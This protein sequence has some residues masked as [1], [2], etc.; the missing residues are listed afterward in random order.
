MDKYKIYSKLVQ[1]ITENLLFSFSQIST[2]NN[3]KKNA[4]LLFLTIISLFSYAQQLPGPRLIVRGDDMGSSRSA[5]LASIETFVNGIETSIE[6]MVVT[7]W[8]PEAVQMLK[9]NTGIDVGLHLVITSE[10]DGI[11]WRP[12]N[13]PSLTDKDGYFY[14]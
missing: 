13:C 1:S 11:K 14:P 6:L 7:P 5:N 2:M 3:L 8:F 10:R 4:S 9:K 12:L